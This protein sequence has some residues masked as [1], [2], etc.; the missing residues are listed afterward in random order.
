MEEAV[1]LLLPR[2][3]QWERQFLS[4]SPRSSPGSRPM[5]LEEARGWYE[6]YAGWLERGL[7]VHQVSNADEASRF[8]EGLR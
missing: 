7:P 3:E 2:Q 6:R 4:R 8:I 1:V 5:G